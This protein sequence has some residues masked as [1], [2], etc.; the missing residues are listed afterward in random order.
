MITG[1][2]K[3]IVIVGPTAVGKTAVAIDVAKHFKTEIISAD[4]RQLFRELSIGTAKPTPAELAT[5]PHHFINTHSIHETYDAAKFGKDAL[6][7]IQELFERHDHLV[8]CGGSGLYVK[9][10]CEGFDDIPPIPGEIRDT[11]EKEYAANGIG[12]L[13][14][15]LKRLDPDHFEKIDQQNTHRLIR[16]L[17]VILGTGKPITSFQKRN[18]LQHAFSIVKVGLELSREELYRRIDARMDCMI[19]EGLFMEAEELYAFRD[20]NAL[21]TVGYQEI[22][23]FMNGSYDQAEA[24]R[25]LKRNS[26]RYAKRQMTWFKHDAEIVWM[27]PANIEGIIGLASS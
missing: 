5:V 7:L 21:Q 17:E 23:D 18:K 11:L 10:V 13:Q 20:H 25:L 26:R 3:L 16:A 2:K 22:F 4:S 15:R 8:L 1:N 12:A 27:N 9:A 6:G 24:I 19:A 14:A